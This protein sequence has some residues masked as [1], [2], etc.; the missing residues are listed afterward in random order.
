ME[1]IKK[2][3]NEIEQLKF[4]DDN[5]FRKIS[6]KVNTIVNYIKDNKIPCMKA[7]E[8]LKSL[9]GALSKDEK[10]DD[11]IVYYDLAKSKIKEHLYNDILKK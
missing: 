2:T 1:L 5:D 9:I 10:E 11:R 3:V 7:P 6:E 8:L 4:E